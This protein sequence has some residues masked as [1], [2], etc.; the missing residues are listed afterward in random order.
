MVEKKTMD[1][2]IVAAKFHVKVRSV[3]SQARKSKCSKD[4]LAKRFQKVVQAKDAPLL[5]ALCRKIKCAR[6]KT[7]RWAPVHPATSCSLSCILSCS[8]S[9]ILSY[10][11]CAAD[12]PLVAP[13]PFI[14]D[15]CMVPRLQPGGGRTP[16]TILVSYLVS[17]LLSYRIFYPQRIFP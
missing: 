16:G 14:H 5:R 1:S 2:L 10:I 17:Y 7:R 9:S 13:C 12:F 4:E 3:W 6:Y 15:K 8:L 11:L